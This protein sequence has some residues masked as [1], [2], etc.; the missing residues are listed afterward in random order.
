MTLYHSRSEYAYLPSGEICDISSKKFIGCSFTL[1]IDNNIIARGYISSNNIIYSYGK[2]ISVSI[3]SDNKFVFAYQS[4]NIIPTTI[5]EPIIVFGS[6]ILNKIQQ[7]S[8][9]SLVTLINFIYVESN[10]FIKSPMISECYEYVSANFQQNERCCQYQIDIAYLIYDLFD[11]KKYNSTPISDIIQSNR[12]LLKAIAV[13]IIDV[14][15][16]LK[17][18]N[19]YHDFMDIIDI[20]EQRICKKDHY[21]NNI[22]YKRSLPP[23]CSTNEEHNQRDEYKKKYDMP[24]KYFDIL[25]CIIETMYQCVSIF[26]SGTIKYDLSIL[27]NIINGYAYTHEETIYHCNNKATSEQYDEYYYRYSHD[28][29]F[30]ID[31]MYIVEHVKILFGKEKFKRAIDDNKPKKNKKN[32]LIEKEKDTYKYKSKQFI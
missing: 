4:R 7:F 2:K 18:V 9:Y 32:Y 16:N 30:Y 22:F 11:P 10:I 28:Y 14:I 24:I 3:T 27:T 8:L 13:N 26:I 6:N 19:T 31:D 20:F 29:C 5:F 23:F 12:D 25:K 21:L 15:N 17:K 1:N